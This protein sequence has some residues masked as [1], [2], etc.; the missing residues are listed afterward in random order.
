MKTKSHSALATLV[1]AALMGVLIGGHPPTAVAQD[2]TTT[3]TTTTQA[4]PPPP[5]P[6]PPA[7]A[8]T[9]VQT[10]VTTTVPSR[11]LYIRKAASGG[12]SDGETV[13]ARPDGKVYNGEG[14]YVGHLTTL[15]GSDIDAIPLRDE[16]KLRSP[17]GTLIA[18]TRPSSAYDSDRKV[19][20]KKQ[21][22]PVP[23]ESTTT[24]TTRQTTT[25]TP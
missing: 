2:Q 5:P 18:S 3:T 19:T 13:Y 1:G 14:D 12:L 4:V 6:P 17:G 7:P 16:F 11:Q 21:D 22:K 8:T 25:T 9:T 15:G 23:A 10:T 24:T 20:V